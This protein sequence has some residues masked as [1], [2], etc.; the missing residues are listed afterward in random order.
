MLERANGGPQVLKVWVN[1]VL[2]RMGC[3]ASKSTVSD[4]LY[5]LA[6]T[7]PGKGNT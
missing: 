3:K 1:N 4:I 2:E 5:T 6:Y 7:T